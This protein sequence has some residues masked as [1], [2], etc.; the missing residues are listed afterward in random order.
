MLECF[1]AQRATTGRLTHLR[2]ANESDKN[3]LEKRL[4]MLTTELDK[5]KYSEVKDTEKYQLLF[6]IYF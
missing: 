2:Q 6:I 3:K 5:Y 4:E 1:Y